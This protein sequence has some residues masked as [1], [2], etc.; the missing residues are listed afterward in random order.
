MGF[1][2]VS[3]PSDIPEG[4]YKHQSRYYRRNRKWNIDQCR[5]YLPSPEIKPGEKERSKYPEYGINRHR[6]HRCK[7]SQLQCFYGIRIRYSLCICLPSFTQRIG[8][9]NN[10]RKNQH[11]RQKQYGNTDQ[12]ITDRASGFFLVRIYHFLYGID[13]ISHDI[14]FVSLFLFFRH[15]CSPFPSRLAELLHIDLHRINQ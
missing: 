9:D 1:Q 2:E 13:T 8:N 4:Q 10:Q 11:D 15:I 12:Y 3:H 7:H 14:L 6:A 5:Q